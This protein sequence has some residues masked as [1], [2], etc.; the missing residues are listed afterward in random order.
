MF[1]DLRLSKLHKVLIVSNLLARIKFL[2]FIAM[3]SAMYYN[4][5][6]NLVKY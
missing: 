3:L 5:N 4:N 6:D 1:Y 2:L